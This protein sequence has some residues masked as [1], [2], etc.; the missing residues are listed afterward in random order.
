[1]LVH[2][3]QNNVSNAFLDVAGGGRLQSVEM[4]WYNN[5]ISKKTIGLLHFKKQRQTSF[6]ASVCFFFPILPKQ[7]EPTPNKNHGIK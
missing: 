6:V 4:N 3:A 2:S 7:K 1:M 5:D